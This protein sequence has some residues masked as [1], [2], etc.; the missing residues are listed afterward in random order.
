MRELPIGYLSAAACLP[1]R[2]K[3]RYGTPYRDLA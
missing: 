2:K 3:G 1:G